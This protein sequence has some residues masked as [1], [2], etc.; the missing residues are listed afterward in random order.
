MYED[1]DDLRDNC[2]VEYVMEIAIDLHHTDAERLD[3]VWEVTGDGEFRIGLTQLVTDH[4]EKAVRAKQDVDIDL[5]AME[6]LLDSYRDDEMGYSLYLEMH[7]YCGTDAVGDLCWSVLESDDEAVRFEKSA[8][9][10]IIDLL[11]RWVD[12]QGLRCSV[13]VEEIREL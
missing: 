5:L 2:P 4:W 10:G 11:E 8:S 12:S 6:V 3:E 1:F 13:E 7:A 9:G